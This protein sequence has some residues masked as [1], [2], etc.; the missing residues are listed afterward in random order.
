VSLTFD[1]QA[2]APFPDS[3]PRREMALWCAE[4]A[5]PF[6]IAADQRLHNLLKTGRPE[7][8]I[9]SPTTVSRDV[10]KIFEHV[11]AQLADLLQVRSRQC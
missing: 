2:F 5:R 1:V 10:R 6:Q 4:S 9:P 8:P 11:K 3:L 7:Y